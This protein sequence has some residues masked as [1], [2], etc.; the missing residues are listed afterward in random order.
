MPIW[1]REE[2]ESLLRNA[3][4]TVRVEDRETAL[5]LQ[6]ALHWRRPAGSA[7]VVRVK[8][9]EVELSLRPPPPQLE[10]IAQAPRKPQP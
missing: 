1:P 6:R 9:V 2:L 4:C 5:K 3:P 8:G 7:V 10:V